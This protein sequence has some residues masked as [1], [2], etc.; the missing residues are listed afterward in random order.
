MW[1]AAMLPCNRNDLQQRMRI[2]TAGNRRQHIVCILAAIKHVHAIKIKIH[3]MYLRMMLPEV[4]PQL[5]N[6]MAPAAMH[7]QQIFAI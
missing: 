3:N 6:I 1:I 7:E 5:V 2:R 4:V